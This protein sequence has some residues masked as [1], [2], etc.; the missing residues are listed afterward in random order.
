LVKHHDV[1]ELVSIFLPYVE[2]VA[3][4]PKR[5]TNIVG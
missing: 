5:G 2:L 1:Q 3:Q 4:K